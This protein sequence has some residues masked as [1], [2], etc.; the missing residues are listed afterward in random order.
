MNE[1]LNAQTLK[2]NLTV[3]KAEISFQQ[4]ELLYYEISTIKKKFVR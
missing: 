1:E 3:E 4:Y 2:L